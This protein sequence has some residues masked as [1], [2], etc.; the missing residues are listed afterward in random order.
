M[1]KSPSR[2]PHFQPD[3]VFNFVLKLAVAIC[4][5]TLAVSLTLGVSPLTSLLRSGVAFVVF[6]T[7][8]WAASQLWPVIEIE[9]EEEAESEAEEA[10]PLAETGRVSEK[11][12]SRNGSA[13]PAA[14][15]E[16]EEVTY[17]PMR[18]TAEMEPV[19]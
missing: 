12:S 18:E 9:V 14:V 8:A 17:Q 7:L 6:A 15:E 5:A 3:W 1:A 13:Q 19:G 11:S 10:D 2:K 16:E 4:L